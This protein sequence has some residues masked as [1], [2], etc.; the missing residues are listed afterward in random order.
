[1]LS[2]PPIDN[3]QAIVSLKTKNCQLNELHLGENCKASNYEKG[4]EAERLAKNYMQTRFGSAFEH[5]K[6]QVGQTPEGPVWHNFD[7]VSHTAK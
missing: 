7:L 6:L 3:K 4:Q 5:K 1:L 2:Y